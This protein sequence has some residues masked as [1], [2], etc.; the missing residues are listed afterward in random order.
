MGYKVKQEKV[1]NIIENNMDNSNHELF[2]KWLEN[3][4]DYEIT[5]EVYDHLD[6]NI[7]DELKELKEDLI[8]KTVWTIGGDGWA[9]DIGFG[10]IDHVVSTNEDINILV[11]DTQVYSNTGGQVSKSSPKGS[12][13]AFAKDGKKASSK[14]M[15]RMLMAYPHVYV[16]QV[17]I[18]ANP[19]QLLKTLKEAAAYDGPSVVIAYTPCIAHGIDGGLENSLEHEKNAT[20]CGFFPIFRYNPVEKKFYLDSKEVNFDLYIDFL[21]TQRRF[22]MLKAVNEEK[23]NQLFEEQKESAIERFNYYKELSERNQ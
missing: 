5:K 20:K 8:K 6:E 14:D 1:K 16:A 17:N 15:A 11:L 4:N 22:K 2:K 12:M 13:L 10:G 21:N 18:G 3:Y 9:Y 7:P 23:A 19:M